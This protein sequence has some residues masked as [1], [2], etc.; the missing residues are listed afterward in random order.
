MAKQE[1]L[2]AIRDRYQESSKK[3]KSRILD[4][5]I[6]VTGH[7]RKY[8]IRLLAQTG[9][10]AGRSPVVKGRRIYDEAVREAVIVIWEA[11]DR[12]LRQT[13]EG[14]AAQPGGVPT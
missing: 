7:H 2:A 5:F 9:Y 13:A 6:A 10:D 11:A 8:G 3:E 1:L 14:G 12:D 4:E